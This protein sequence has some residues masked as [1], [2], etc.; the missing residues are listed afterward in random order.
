ML[1][2]RLPLPRTRAQWRLGATVGVPLF[3]LDYGLIYSGAQHIT[4][5]LTAALF[6]ALPL[7]TGLVAHVALPDERFTARKAA[8][9]AMGVVGVAVVFGDS[10][11]FDVARLPAM[12]AIVASAFCAAL[13]N[14]ATRREGRK[15]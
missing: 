13:S 2:L 12:A 1:A 5:S 15:L 3:T 8:G 7:L 14:V 6:A 11:R 10:L 9:I 4:S